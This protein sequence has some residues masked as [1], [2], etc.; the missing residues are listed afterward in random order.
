MKAYHTRAKRF[1]EW[2]TADINK[3]LGW[4]GHIEAE[5]FHRKQESRGYKWKFNIRK[6]IARKTKY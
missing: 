3:V 1:T 6:R 4:R 2:K 5:I